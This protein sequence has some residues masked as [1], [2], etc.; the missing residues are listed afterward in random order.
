VG[1][2]SEFLGEK[3]H[4]SPCFSAQN[5]RQV[6]FRAA[7]GPPVRDVLGQPQAQTTSGVVMPSHEKQKRARWSVFVFKPNLAFSEPS[8]VP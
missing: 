8:I 7:Q 1:R 2:G 4:E 6:L 5:L 3:D